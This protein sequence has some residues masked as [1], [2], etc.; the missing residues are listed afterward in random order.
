ML[1]Q[2]VSIGDKFRGTNNT[3]VVCCQHS[4]WNT[5][6]FQFRFVKINV[7]FLIQAQGHLKIS[8]ADVKHI[9]TLVFLFTH[10]TQQLKIVFFCNSNRVYLVVYF[11]NPAFD[12]KAY[13]VI[14]FFIQR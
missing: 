8:Y 14:I 6:K 3:P 7:V 2:L 10:V 9:N 5:G 11:R 13:V 1:K 4:Q 12:P